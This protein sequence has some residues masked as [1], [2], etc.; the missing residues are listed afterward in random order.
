M[1]RLVSHVMVAPMLIGGPRR[2]LVTCAYGIAAILAAL[3]WLAVPVAV[4]RA[5]GPAWT[6]LWLLP[7]T[8]SIFALSIDRDATPE[9]PGSEPIWVEGD[10]LDEPEM[11][12][13]YHDWLEDI[14]KPP[15]R[16]YRFFQSVAIGS[17]TL[18]FSVCVL[19]QWFLWMLLMVELVDPWAIVIGTAIAATQMMLLFKEKTPSRV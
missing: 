14:M 7:T 9:E 10:E 6:L 16:W 2:Y 11:P 3:L 13:G 4:W 12:A 19:E 5:F 8:V 1:M 18:V 17:I 15:P